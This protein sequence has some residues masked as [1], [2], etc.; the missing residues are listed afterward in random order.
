MNFQSKK[1]VH[2]KLLTFESE[3][4]PEQKKLVNIFL[5]QKNVAKK[6]IRQ[7]NRYKI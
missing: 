4:F 1:I 3:K 5:I 2:S 6:N 7:Q